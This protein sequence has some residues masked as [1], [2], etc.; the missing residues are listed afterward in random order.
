[1]RRPICVLF[2]LTILGGCA[3]EPHQ[4]PA[5]A[6]AEPLLIEVE[7]VQYSGPD[8]QFPLQTNLQNNNRLKIAQS[9]G[10]V[11]IDHVIERPLS[12]SFQIVSVTEKFVP[13]TGEREPMFFHVKLTRH[14]IVGTKPPDNRFKLALLVPPREFNENTSYSNVQRRVWF[15]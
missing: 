2:A 1:M 7:P 4:E 15:R 13:L 6:R 9:C 12:T 5:L 8:F 3:N 14:H 11:L 10:G